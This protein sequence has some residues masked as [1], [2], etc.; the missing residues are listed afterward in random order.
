MLKAVF[1][2]LDGTLLPIDEND[3]IKGYFSLLAKKVL[4]HGYE[5]D[6][7][8]KCIWGG[9]ERMI[10]N[11]G[12]K[13]NEEF[14]WSFFTSIYGEEKLKDKPIFDDFYIHEFKDA[15][16]YCEENPFAKEII[17]FCNANLERTILS[18]NPFFPR[19][20][21]KTRLSFIG[22]KDTDFDYVTDYSNSSFCKPNPQ[23]FQTLLDKFNLKGEEVILFGNNTLED[24]DCAS[25]CGIKTYLVN[26]HII[27]NEKAK[28]T[29]EIVNMKDVINTIKKELKNSNN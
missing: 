16:I 5:T 27:D 4:P 11:D 26:G 15:K 12:T 2:D 1:F 25:S 29:F 13:T 24:G 21:Q 20:G 6:K 18:T 28:G 17:D 22:L 9:T 3:F 19:E 8:T 14:F 10:K 23:Y 7:L